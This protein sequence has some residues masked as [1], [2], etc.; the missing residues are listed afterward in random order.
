MSIK[1]VKILTNETKY[2][3]GKPAYRGAFKALYA[4]TIH[5]TL[6]MKPVVSNAGINYCTPDN[7]IFAACR[8][9][10]KGQIGALKNY[11][12][13]VQGG[14][15]I[16]SEVVAEVYNAA[17][18]QSVADNSHGKLD[19]I[20]SDFNYTDKN[21]KNLT[22]AEAKV[23]IADHKKNNNEIRAAIEDLK[24][25]YKWK[26]G[27]KMSSALMDGIKEKMKG[28]F[29]LTGFDVEFVVRN[30]H[31]I[32]TT[33]DYVICSNQQGLE[34]ARE[35]LNYNLQGSR[36]IGSST[37]DR[38]FIPIQTL[39]QLRI[40]KERMLNKRQAWITQLSNYQRVCSDRYNPDGINL[41]EAAAR[42]TELSQ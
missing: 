31:V 24:I 1:T 35:N 26:K 37:P 7:D 12:T 20:L 17:E 34:W 14:T 36:L 6:E 21:G 5:S 39:D 18:A 2:K 22:Y 4:G 16:L 3:S 32:N 23:V 40:F 11:S 9:L 30:Q 13:D 29:S 33:D 10:Q 28:Y 38:V 41:E 25:L 8:R 27:Q 15:T 19:D 42:D